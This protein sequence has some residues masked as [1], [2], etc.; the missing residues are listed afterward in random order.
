LETYLLRSFFSSEL[1]ASSPYFEINCSPNGNWNAYGFNEYRQGMHLADL[2]VE[3]IQAH[4]TS[5]AAQFDVCITGLALK[6]A[7]H[8]GI[9]AILEFHDGSKAYFALKHAGTQADFHL[10]DSFI[11]SL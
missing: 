1:P 8:L 3:L 10:K 7:K 5:A 4:V 9:T 2:T 11:I 6:N